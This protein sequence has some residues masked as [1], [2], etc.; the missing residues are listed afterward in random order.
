MPQAL[1]G[2]VTACTTLSVKWD[3]SGQIGNLYTDYLTIRLIFS[4]RPCSTLDPLL[5]LIY[6]NDMSNSTEYLNLILYAD[7]SLIISTIRIP[8]L[9]LININNG[10]AKVYDWLAVNK[11][12][13][14]V[15]KPQYV[16]FH[17]INK[18][19]EGAIPNLEMNGM[20]L[21]RVKKTQLSWHS[22]K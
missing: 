8:S 22:A 16:I 4:I 17:A 18:R 13:L 21:E 9:P 11:L 1:F 2:G 7:D 20:H 12:S 19:I 10:L 5:F 14:D 15:R 3:F 6:L